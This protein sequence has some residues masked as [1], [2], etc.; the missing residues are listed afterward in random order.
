MKKIGYT[1]KAHPEGT[2]KAIGRE[3]DISPKAS[4]EVCREVRSM[5]VEDAIQ[6]LEEVISLKRPVSY[7]RYNGQVGHRRGKKFGA[8]RYPKKTA[9]AILDVIKHAQHN[10]EYKGLDSDNMRIMHISSSRGMT[11]EGFMP[12]AHGR[13][14]PFNHER[15]NIEVVLEVIEE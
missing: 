3:L 8:G 6:F 14:T 13:S 5:T 1:I 2:A 7:R 10:A 15:A 12:R 11:V 4:V 9:K